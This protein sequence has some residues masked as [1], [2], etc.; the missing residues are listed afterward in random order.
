MTNDRVIPTNS[1]NEKPLCDFGLADV[2]GH[3]VQEE[4]LTRLLW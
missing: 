1:L 4:V 2:F 3:E